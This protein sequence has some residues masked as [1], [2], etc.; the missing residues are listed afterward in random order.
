MNVAK[1]ETASRIWSGAK[2]AEIEIA[3]W[4]LR[5]WWRELI[6]FLWAG[7]SCYCTSDLRSTENSHCVLLQREH[8]HNK[9]LKWT[10]T[11]VVFQ[12]HP[13][14]EETLWSL[15]TCWRDYTL[16]PIWPVSLEGKRSIMFISDQLQHFCTIAPQLTFILSY[17]F[18]LHISKTEMVKM[19]QKQIPVG[20]TNTFCC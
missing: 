2:M 9:W 1:G 10:P 6:S 4:K 15:R 11:S 14:R 17:I 12:T 8:V 18:F 16:H 13:D 20:G 19:W 7:V 5:P 3:D